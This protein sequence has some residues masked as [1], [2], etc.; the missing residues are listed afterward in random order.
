MQSEIL[1]RFSVEHLVRVSIYG[2]Y[3][4]NLKAMN[5]LSAM[6]PLTGNPLAEHLK[7]AFKL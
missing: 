3:Q 2:E 5:D 6:V 1:S 7:R 4:Q